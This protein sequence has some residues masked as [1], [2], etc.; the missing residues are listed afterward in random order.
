MLSVANSEKNDSNFFA[1]LQRL[2]SQSQN[3]SW[4]ITAIKILPV[5]K[6]YLVIK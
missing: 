4:I 1:L 6:K 5:L 2:Q 3:R